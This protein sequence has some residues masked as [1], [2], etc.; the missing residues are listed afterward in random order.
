MEMEGGGL[1]RGREI[2]IT[3]FEFFINWR[4]RI[5]V[6]NGDLPLFWGKMRVKNK[7][8]V[9]AYPLRRRNVAG[10]KFLTKNLILAVEYEG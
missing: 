10:M 3:S 2:L 6:V 7:G 4:Y 8:E 9:P 5:V 1:L